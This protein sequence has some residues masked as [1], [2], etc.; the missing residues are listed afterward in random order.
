MPRGIGP[1]APEPQ[2]FASGATPLRGKPTAARGYSIR[3]RSFSRVSTSS[4]PTS[5]SISPSTSNAGGGV[6]A[7]PG[8]HLP[9]VAGVPDDIAVL[10]L[11]AVALEQIDYSARPGA[12]RIQVGDDFRHGFRIWCGCFRKANCPWDEQDGHNSS[13]PGLR[14]TVSR[15]RMGSAG[16][17]FPGRKCMSMLAQRSREGTRP[18]MLPGANSFLSL[19]SPRMRVVRHHHELSLT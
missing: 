17:P 3:P 19:I 12:G 14:Q 6:L 7:A 10:V 16:A 2:F 1:V 13:C 5:A 9:V 4:S 11:E 15:S 8:H 18:P